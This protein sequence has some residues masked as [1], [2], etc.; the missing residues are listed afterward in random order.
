M[1]P[2]I[3]FFARDYQAKL[4][5]KLNSDTYESVFVA[6]NIKEK[7][8][9]EKEGVKCDACFEELYDSLKEFTFESAYLTTSF[10]S[11]RYLGNFT[12]EER[13]KYLCKAISF[14]SYVFEKFK[15]QFVL[16][17]V[18]AIEFAEVMYIE[19]KKRNIIYLAWMISPFPD[20][21]FYW[22]SNP[23]NASLERKIF[24]ATPEINNL[25]YAEN[26][27]RA[28]NDNKPYYVNNLKNRYSPIILVKTLKKTISSKLFNAFLSKKLSFFYFD[29]SKYFLAQLKSYFA[30]FFYKYD[31]FD[32]FQN[33]EFVFYPL[34]Y[35]PEASLTYFAEFYDDQLN[36]I[37]NI[38]KCLKND[39]YLIVKEHP[40]QPGI[41]LTKK[42]RE[43]RKSISNILFLPAEYPTRKLIDKVELTITISSTAGWESLLAEKPVV[44]IGNVFYDKHPD[45]YLFTN[46]DE[47]KKYICGGLY[48]KPNYTNNL[49]F[50]S[51]FYNHC[52]FGNPYPNSLLYNSQ[53]INFIIESIENIIKS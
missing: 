13:N 45:A 7:K 27:L 44:V 14:W 40:Q 25:K 31:V 50:I 32:K 28:K 15:P 10:T 47:L 41:L 26:L 53:N 17:E 51:Q 34:H 30:S 23:F 6:Y 49:N 21:Q 43:L 35:E 22:L 11:D 42:F 33:F 37:R 18:I 1:K 48:K 52:N 4:F 2:K 16:N 3:L 46:Y 29:H 9:L 24:E 39:Q 38:S 5:P 36:T 12:L 19:A 20:K 8:I